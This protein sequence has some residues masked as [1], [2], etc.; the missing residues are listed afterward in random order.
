M[1][2]RPAQPADA[3]AIAAIYAHYVET[4]AATFDDMGALPELLGA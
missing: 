1:R 4:S 2:I 3:T